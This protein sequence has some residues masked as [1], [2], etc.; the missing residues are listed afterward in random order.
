MILPAL[1]MGLKD[2]SG[3]GFFLSDTFVYPVIILMTF[4]NGFE[5]GIA[6]PASGNLSMIF[7]T[8][9]RKGFF[10]AFFWAFYM[11]SQVV[12]SSI[13]GVLFTNGDKKADTT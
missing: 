11:G 2:H 9:R 10:F 3:R 6:Q 8:E 7:A 13:S 1:N 12:G 4:I 5:Q